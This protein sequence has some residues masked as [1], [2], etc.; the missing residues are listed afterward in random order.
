MILGNGYTQAVDWWSLGAL[1][2]EMLIGRS[3]FETKNKNRKELHKKILT[4]KVHD[5]LYNLIYQLCD[6]S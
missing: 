4:A 5:D 2:Y 6:V 3:P 1:A